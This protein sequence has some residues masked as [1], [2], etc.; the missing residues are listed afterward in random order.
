MD[1]CIWKYEKGLLAGTHF[2]VASCC[3]KTKVLQN[4]KGSASVFGCADMYNWQVC[5]ECGKPIEMDYS[6][7]GKQ[8]PIL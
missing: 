7:L 2:A 8:G 3:G 4:A 1:T 6:S 5:P